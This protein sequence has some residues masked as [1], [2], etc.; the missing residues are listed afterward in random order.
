MRNYDE[1]IARM[2]EADGVRMA[3][4]QHIGTPHTR[5]GLYHHAYDEWMGLCY[6]CNHPREAHEGEPPDADPWAD[7]RDDDR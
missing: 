7:R 3:S 1:M 5:S 4:G 6:V 2:T